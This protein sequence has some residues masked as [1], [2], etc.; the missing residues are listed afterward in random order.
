MSD[1]SSDEMMA[2]SP[3]PSLIPYKTKSEAVYLLLREQIMLGRLAAGELLNQD[4][5]AK[6]LGTS[7]TPIR[8]ALRRLESDGFVS[9][10]AHRGV[11]VAPL[12]LAELQHLFRVKV[13]LELLAVEQA[14][15]RAT[16]VEREQIVEL[17]KTSEHRGAEADVS[18]WYAN[19]RFHQAVYRASG[20]AILISILETLWER[21]DRYFN[22]FNTIVFYDDTAMSEHGEIAAAV[23]DG[24]AARAHTWMARHHLH[25]LTPITENK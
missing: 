10:E 18:E 7:V 25:G 2:L 15:E 12:D 13:S 16:T 4:Q 1:K 6:S 8:E 9:N 19:K 23:F 14:A 11:V 17:S 22:V 21:Y 5:L 24:D 3:A 20:N